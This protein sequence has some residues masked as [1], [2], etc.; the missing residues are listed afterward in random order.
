MRWLVLSIGVA[1]IA[2]AVWL[3]RRNDAAVHDTRPG[4][5]QR[6]ASPVLGYF[7]G[8]LLLLGGI[9]AVLFAMFVLG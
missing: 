4:A 1:L 9:F 2:A 8:F 5:L 7:A 6:P 3:F